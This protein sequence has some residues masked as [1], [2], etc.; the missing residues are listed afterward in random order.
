MKRFAPFMLVG[1]LAGLVLLAA[2]SRHGKPPA[3]R[4]IGNYETAEVMV[5]ARMEVQPDGQVRVSAPDLLDVGELS[6]A[7]RSDL[8][9][10][11]ADKLVESW[12]KAEPRPMDFDGRTFRKPGGVAPQAEWNPNSH[13]MKLVFY[14]GMEHSIRIQ[15]QQVS[16]F[17]ADPWKRQIP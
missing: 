5:D 8:H 15:M 13:E 7:E 17:S 6:D 1:L 12:D 14:F 10:R 9:A 3:G 11:L 4:W 16:E 2:C